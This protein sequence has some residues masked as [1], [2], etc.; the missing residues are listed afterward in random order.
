MTPSSK[1][2]YPDTS[3]WQADSVRICIVCGIEQPI[4]NFEKNSRGKERRHQCRKCR[5]DMHKVKAGIKDRKLF[6][7]YIE[8]DSI[9]MRICTKCLVPQPF[10]NFPPNNK[11]LDGLSS[12]CKSCK[13]KIVKNWVQN[14][15]QRLKTRAN[16][17]ESAETESLIQVCTTCN[18]SKPLE[19]FYRNYT[20]R[21]GRH[22]ECKVCSDVRQNEWNKANPERVK[23][24][25]RNNPN[26]KIHS[27]RWRDSNKEYM[28]AKGKQWRDM[29]PD[30]VRSKQ[31]EKRFRNYGVTQEWYDQIL[32]EQGG[33]CAICGSIDP[34]S[35]GN[36]FHVDHDHSCCSKGCHACDRCRR[37]LLCSPCNTRL[38]HLENRTWL[39]K[40]KAYLK[41]Y[42]LKDASGN[43]QPSLFDVL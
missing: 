37:G 17:I 32:A 14:N 42:Q 6:D 36:T 23:Q 19:E 18:I 20:S 4:E 9:K 1:P 28:S 27:K 35:N 25:R 31:I 3:K 2:L 12:Q 5:Y 15:A 8:K 7:R 13:G 41:K 39:P 10:E 26:T 22:T 43:D 24:A 16:E 33:C 11:M 30:R 34:K 40:A 21:Y 29:N 38:A